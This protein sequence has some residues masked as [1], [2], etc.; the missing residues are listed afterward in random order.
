M[1]L[2]FWIKSNDILF[3][4]YLLFLFYICGGF[5]FIFLFFNKDVIN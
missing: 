3:K 4:K 1:F 5:K 2:M